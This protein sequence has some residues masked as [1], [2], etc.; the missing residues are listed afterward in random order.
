[1]P[2]PVA[3]MQSKG[4]PFLPCSPR[5]PRDKSR[6]GL[7]T[8]ANLTPKRVE[9]QIVEMARTDNTPESQR[10]SVTL[11]ATVQ[12]L[13]NDGKFSEAEDMARRDLPPQEAA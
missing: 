5:T 13:V 7:V 3:V 1:M 8:F 2:L 6:E 10:A 4:L 12:N 9:R 11:H